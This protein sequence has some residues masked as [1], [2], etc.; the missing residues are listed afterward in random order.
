MKIL[1]SSSAAVMCL[2]M[3]RVFLSEHIFTWAPSFLA[4]SYAQSQTPLT[5]FD[6]EPC[7][8]WG[9]DALRNLFGKCCGRVEVCFQFHCPSRPLHCH[10]HQKLGGR[11]QKHSKE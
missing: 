4:H 1:T 6:V 8:S 7:A 2:L 10:G 11:Q 3:S 9:T 5:G